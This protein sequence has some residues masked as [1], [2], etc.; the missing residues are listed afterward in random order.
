M[1]KR[2]KCSVMMIALHLRKTEIIN[3]VIFLLSL[4]KRRT[5]KKERERQKD[6]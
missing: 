2:K 1:I 5:I 4:G 3:M 6:V